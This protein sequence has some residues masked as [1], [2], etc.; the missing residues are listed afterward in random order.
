[1]PRQ[2]ND[3]IWPRTWNTYSEVPGY[4]VKFNVDNHSGLVIG[5]LVAFSS[6]SDPDGNHIHYWYDR[7]TNQ[8]GYQMKS[9]GVRFQSS[10]ADS[11]IE[12]I[13]KKLPS[14]MLN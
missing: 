10:V 6:E 9:G 12:D 11:V 4:K 5:F 14:L 3:R 8:A 2:N 1:M 7:G 13:R